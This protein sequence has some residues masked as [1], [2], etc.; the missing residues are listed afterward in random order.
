[1]DGLDA[2]PMGRALAVLA[3]LAACHSA[4]PAAPSV[5]PANDESP[6]LVH[7]RVAGILHLE[8]LT[9]G[10]VIP[11]GD[12]FVT[13]SPKPLLYVTVSRTDSTI[14]SSL[15]TNSGVVGTAEANWQ[16]DVQRAVRIRWTQN[17]ATLM[18]WSMTL[19]GGVIHIA[20][21]R[22]TAFRVPSLPSA[23]ADHGVADQQPPPAGV[24][25][26]ALR[27]PTLPWVVA[28]YGME[29]QLLPLIQAACRH[30]QRARLAVYRPYSAKWVTI[31]IACRGIGGAT[32]VTETK[33]DGE[34]FFWTISADGA[35]VRLTRDR[36]PEFERRPLELSA[37]FTDYVRTLHLWE[38]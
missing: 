38:H 20:G 22:D 25:N 5:A 18:E 29:D 11:A 33:Q 36:D 28:E 8:S 2:L 17:R 9:T 13:W 10:R 21:R 12:T 4:A 27:T 3:L 30:K 34:H 19:Q 1:M 15:V 24:L 32:L 26:T 16:G 35:L 23:A 14:A 7:F 31:A 6:D 37:R